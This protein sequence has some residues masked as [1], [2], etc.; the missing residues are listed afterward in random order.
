MGYLRL[1]N[2]VAR[3]RKGLHELVLVA[4]VKLGQ[5]L[6]LGKILNSK[7][8]DLLQAVRSDFALAELL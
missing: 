4:L 8:G 1:L 2:L 7:V 6:V 5:L 3:E